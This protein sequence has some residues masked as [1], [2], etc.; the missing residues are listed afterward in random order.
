MTQHR[1]K[2]YVDAF[3]PLA[4]RPHCA[5]QVFDVSFYASQSMMLD[6]GVVNMLSRPAL[7]STPPEPWQSMSILPSYEVYKAYYSY[8]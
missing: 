8:L 4:R 5:P 7:V 1:R 6:W 2:E 3:A